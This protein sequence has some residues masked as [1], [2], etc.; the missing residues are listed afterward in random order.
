MSKN[1][2]SDREVGATLDVL[3]RPLFDK[4]S[5]EKKFEVM[6]NFA[7]IIDAQIKGI[8]D[9]TKPETFS[10]FMLPETTD[11]MISYAEN[12]LRAAGYGNQS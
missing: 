11:F 2:P 8:I 10:H 9:L 12:M 6:M 1:E 4:M 5:E 3:I 7:T